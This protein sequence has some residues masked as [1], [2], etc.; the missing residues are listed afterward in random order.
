MG[1]EKEEKKR[2]RD[3]KKYQVN[4]E[5]A[6]NANSSHIFMHCLPAHIDEEVTLEVLNSK[7]SIVYEQAE[8]KVYAA[9][10]ILDFLL[11]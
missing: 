1:M 3:F 7:N 5:I 6:S 8:N 10:A 4:K 11:S 9:M 2:L